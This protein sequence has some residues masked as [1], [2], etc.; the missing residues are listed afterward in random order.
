MKRIMLLANLDNFIFIGVSLANTTQ[1]CT[2]WL[3]RPLHA[4]SHSVKQFVQR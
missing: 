1:Q 2:A 4:L 3:G